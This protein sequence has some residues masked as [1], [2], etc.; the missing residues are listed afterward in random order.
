MSKPE[1]EVTQLLV[2]WGNGDP[3]ALEQLVPVVHRELRNLARHYLNRESPGHTLQPTALVNE[4]F[5]KLI[6]GNTVRWENRA[7]F[8]GIAAKLMRE[9]LV[10][11]ARRRKQLKRGGDALRVSL[12][13][14]DAS[15][16]R[17]DSDVLALDDALKS[18][19]EFDEL[20]SRIVELRFFGGLTEEETS[21]ALNIPLRTLQREWRLTR[22]WLSNQML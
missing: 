3:A 13:S 20:K 9:I 4:A 12:T 11:H 5:L 2:A 16:D 14:A 22:A 17:K 18:L 21:A 15:T 7:H 19:A 6:G 1:G 8:F 10:D